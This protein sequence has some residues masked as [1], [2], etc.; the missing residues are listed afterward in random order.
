MPWDHAPA[1]SDFARKPA[2]FRATPMDATT[3]FRPSRGPLDRALGNNLARKCGPTSSAASGLANS[4]F[5]GKMLAGYRSSLHHLERPTMPNHF[6]FLAEYN[7][8]A[9]LE[10]FAILDREDPAI[11]RK[12]TGIY[13]KSILGHL[14][15]FFC[16][17]S[18]GWADSSPKTRTS[19]SSWGHCQPLACPGRGQDLARLAEFRFCPRRGRRCL[20]KA[21][22][23]PT[24]GTCRGD[25]PLPESQR[26]ATSQAALGDSRAPV[27]SPDHHPRA[28]CHAFDQA[29]IANDYSGLAPKFE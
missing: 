21:D 8:K 7:R 16:R 10:L 6:K 25:F 29:G 3:R 19:D 2:E 28:D 14:A 18:L 9:N 11:L 22:S 12:Q 20:C 5:L 24:R 15:T 17:T 4:G 13:F 27:Q 1:R 26:R 23:G